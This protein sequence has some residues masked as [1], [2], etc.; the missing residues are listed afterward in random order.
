MTV[1]EFVPQQ[2]SA[3]TRSLAAGVPPAPPGTLFVLGAHGGY[4]VP[5]RAFTLLFG[6]ESEDVHV[7]VGVDD[8]YVSRFHGRLM[9][10]GTEWWLR[11]TGRLPMRLPR[12]AMLL[13][14]QEMPLEDGYLPLFIGRSR[15]KE[16][17]VELYVVGRGPA[18]TL[19]GPGTDTRSPAVYEL[20]DTERLVLAALAQRYLR[21]ERHPQ[22]VAWKQVADDLNRLG[23]DREW[24]AHG[25]ANVVGRVR[26]RLAK[27][28]DG[29][30]PLPGVLRTEGAGEPLGNALNHNLIQALLTTTTLL[31]SDL[32][33]LGD[34]DD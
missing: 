24:T 27:G 15:R 31:P 33:L 30:D 20:S 18:N 34:L 25:A 26:E 21:Y 6:R 9:C 32:R 1:G 23:D 10:D 13:A 14:G 7:A 2:L 16:H 22:P 17:L 8:P 11:N 5:P 12:E 3:S 4:A 19:G 29:A 28:V